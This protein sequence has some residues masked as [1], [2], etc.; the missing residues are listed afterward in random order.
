MNVTLKLELL[1]I[2]KKLLQIDD[3]TIYDDQL[4]L[5]LESSSQSMLS[6]I[7]Y[8]DILS[9]WKEQYAL[10]LMTDFIPYLEMDIDLTKMSRLALTNRNQLRL[11]KPWINE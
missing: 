9:N 2:V 10:C 1:N 7:P 3:T 11:R 5:L 8:P 6:E 4:N